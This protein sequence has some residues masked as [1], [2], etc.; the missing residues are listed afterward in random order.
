LPID[1]SVNTILQHLNLGHNLFQGTIPEILGFEL[2]SLK[3]LDVSGNWLEGFVPSSLAYLPALT[4]LH[5][6]DNSYEVATIPSWITTMTG[7]QELTMDR[8][9]LIGT[10][11]PELFSNLRHLKYIDLSTNELDGSIPG[12]IGESQVLEYLLLQKNQLTGRLPPSMAL[13]SDLS[14]LL[15]QDNNLEGQVCAVT[16]SDNNIAADCE[17]VDCPCCKK[18]CTDGNSCSVDELVEGIEDK[19]S[20]KF[21]VKPGTPWD[22]RVPGRN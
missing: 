20:E 15:I 16:M 21:Y 11:S 3:Y 17:E 4:S 7:L 8:S 6:G 12:T 13:L 19:H 22:F 10:I 5:V 14:V 1:I 9:H 2:Q 18:C